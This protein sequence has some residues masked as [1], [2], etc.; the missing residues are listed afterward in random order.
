MNINKLY[1]LV[2]FSFLLS[3]LHSCTNQKSD[4]IRIGVLNGPSA[5]SFIKLIDS[6]IK[7]DNKKLDIIIKNEPLQIQALMMKN[8]LDFAILPT[9]MAANLYNKGLKYKMLACPVWGTLYLLSDGSINSFNDLEGQSVAV[10]GQ[11]GTADV[12]LSRMIEKNKLKKVHINYTYTTNNELSQALL[13][14]KVKLAVVSEP[15]V[16]NLISQNK[17]LKIVSKITC[18]AYIDKSDKDIFVQTVFVV[19][20]RFI[21]K[22]PDIIKDV[23]AAYTSS[24]NFITEEPDSVANLMV[25][26]SFSPNK[27]TAKLSLPFCNIQYTAAFAINIELNEYLNIFY[28]I[29]PQSLGGKMPNKGFIYQSY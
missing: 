18:E 26:Y 6:P 1:Y 3:L 7:I 24:C 16:S 27:E 14:G 11:G 2:V 19:S 10:F 25:K 23:T 12:L 17:S 29:N 5:I 20:E 9:V 4:D 15:M 22:Y 13:M 21:N 28:Q 8:Q